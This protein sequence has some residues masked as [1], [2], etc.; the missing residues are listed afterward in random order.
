MRTI[1][2]W[3]IKVII[4]GEEKAGIPL[5]GCLVDG[6]IEA[7]KVRIEAIDISISKLRCTDIHGEKYI[8]AGARSE[9]IGML[10]KAIEFAKENGLFFE[11]NN[12]LN[13]TEKQESNNYDE[14]R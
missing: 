1:E 8:L 9:Y 13:N 4:D 12:M 5:P 11:E 6:E 14:E 7:E 2:N 3:E 10:N